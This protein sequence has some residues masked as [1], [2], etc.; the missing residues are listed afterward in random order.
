MAPAKSAMPARCDGC[1]IDAYE[2]GEECVVVRDRAAVVTPA[3]LQIFD[4]TPPEDLPQ[5]VEALLRDEFEDV[6]R[7]AVADRSLPD[8]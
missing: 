7:Q 3:L 5:R 4:T 6:Q 1:D 2:I 8:A